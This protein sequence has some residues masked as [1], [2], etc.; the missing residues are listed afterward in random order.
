MKKFSLVIFNE[1]FW[2]KGLIYSQNIKPLIKIAE[3]HTD[4]KIEFISFTSILMWVINRSVIAEQISTFEKM[5][6]EVKIFPVFFYPTRYMIVRWF[7][8]PWYIIN[9]FPFLLYL[10]VR[11][12]FGRFT[13]LY[14]LRSYQ[15]SLAFLLLYFGKGRRVFDTRTDWIEE[16]RGMNYWNTGGLT[17]KMWLR[18]ERS[19]INKF[20]RTLFIS[21]TQKEDTLERAKLQDC[22]KYS[23]FYNQTDYSRYEMDKTKR[24][25]DDF[26]YSGS[27]GHWNNLSTYLDFFVKVSDVFPNSKLIVLTPTTKDKIELV[28]AREKYDIVRNRVEV[29]YNIPYNEIPQ[30]YRR[31]KYGL[32]LMEKADSRVGVKFVEYVAAG[33]IPIVHENV[34]GASYLAENMGLGVVVGDALDEKKIIEIK[35][36]TITQEAYKKFKQLTD[37]KESNGLLYKYLV[38]NEE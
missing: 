5:G 35:D 1:N 15:T 30:Y 16:A 32:Q 2:D 29:Y 20:D 7:L 21:D 22:N 36:C 4:S 14:I 10:S 33:L 17:D 12:M 24:Q 34:R 3:N 25:S 13:R 28:L 9:T 37:E 38:Q 27:L 11:D 26:I 18:F 31:C 19:I 23:V 6:I 8:L